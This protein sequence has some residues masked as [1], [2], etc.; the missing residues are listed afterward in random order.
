[1]KPTQMKPIQIKPTQ[2]KP[3]QMKPT[4]MKPTQMTPTSSIKFGDNTAFW[5]YLHNI[6][7]NTN[8]EVPNILRYK[9]DLNKFRQ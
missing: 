8:T 6:F 3:S 2:M 4:Q 7:R 9:N 5:K 1:M